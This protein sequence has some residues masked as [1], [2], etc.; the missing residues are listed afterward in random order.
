MQV[1]AHEGTGWQSAFTEELIKEGF[2]VKVI[3]KQ[4]RFGRVHAVL[5]DEKTGRWIGGADP[6]WE[7]AVAGEKK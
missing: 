2:D 5:F 3:D 7:G 1:E 6:D 4:A